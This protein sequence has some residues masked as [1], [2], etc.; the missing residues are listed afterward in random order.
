[1]MFISILQVFV[2]IIIPVY[3][4][5]KKIIP[6][7][8]RLHTIFTI[9]L[10]TVLF[11]YL[12]GMTFYDLGIRFDNI[13]QSLFPYISF[14]ILISIAIFYV[15]KYV[16]NRNH[17]VHYWSEKK[18]HIMIF[19]PLCFLQ[20]F[21]FR[22]YLIPKLFEIFNS[23]IIVVFINALLFMSIHLVYSTKKIDLLFV[24]LEG[25]LLAMIFVL[26]PN[27]IFVTIAHA[28]HNFIAIFFKF[29]TEERA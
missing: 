12:E 26:Y 4:L 27:L 7:K 8:Y 21:I 10:L 17:Y 1:M 6:F 18:F 5:Y 3:L 29:F 22:G 19:L 2:L 28:I 20:E 24:F 9:F 25:F 11:I 14:T 23:S 16:L 13:S 15:S